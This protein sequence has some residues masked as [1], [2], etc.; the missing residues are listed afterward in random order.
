MHAFNILHICSF[1]ELLKNHKNLARQTQKQ[2]MHPLK[3]NEQVYL[4]EKS[5]ELPHPVI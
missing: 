2:C 3:E 5:H 1:C 4:A